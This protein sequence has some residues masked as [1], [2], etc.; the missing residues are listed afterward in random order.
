MD[1]ITGNFLT[2]PN[3]DFPLDCETLD[4]LQTNAALVATLGNLIG[5]KLILDGCG[6][7]NNGTQR[8]PGYVFLRSK[9]Y[10][11]G[12]VLRW[13]GATYRAACT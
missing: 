11:D 1:K 13:E 9:D 4:L 8:A 7:S 3:K 2:Q 6:L 5:D 10:P 12:E